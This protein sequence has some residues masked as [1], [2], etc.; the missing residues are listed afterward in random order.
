MGIYKLQVIC[1]K[2]FNL[3]IA[4]FW[5]YK[6]FHCRVSNKGAVLLRQVIT[7]SLLLSDHFST[8]RN[9]AVEKSWP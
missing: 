1:P 9:V 4:S 5:K 2:L 6:A 7:N 3:L 8:R